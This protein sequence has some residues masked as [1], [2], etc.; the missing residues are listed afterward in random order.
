MEPYFLEEAIQV[1][2]S[3]PL[4]FHYTTIPQGSAK[5]LSGN[6]QRLQAACFWDKKMGSHPTNY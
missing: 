1:L 3:I 4:Q 6:Q 5:A 2:H